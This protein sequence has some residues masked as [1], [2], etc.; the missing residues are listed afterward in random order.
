MMMGGRPVYRVN[1]T[2][3]RTTWWAA[4]SVPTTFRGAPLTLILTVYSGVQ[5]RSDDDLYGAIHI[6]DDGTLKDGSEVQVINNGQIVGAGDPAG[7]GGDGLYVATPGRLVITNG[8]GW[9]YGGYTSPG[10]RGY[11]VRYGTST[12]L[13]WVSGATRVTGT[14]GQ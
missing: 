4:S 6:P 7:V 3:N 1:F 10:A 5:I 11:A 8:S 9:I 14:V 2:S 12:T 13:S